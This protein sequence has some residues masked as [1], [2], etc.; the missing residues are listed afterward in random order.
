MVFRFLYLNTG[1]RHFHSANV[2]DMRK[3]ISDEDQDGPEG[4]TPH[5]HAWST[6]CGHPENGKAE[7]RAD[8]R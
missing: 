4:G 2:T 6:P 8:A 7:T 1:L 5:I 3:A